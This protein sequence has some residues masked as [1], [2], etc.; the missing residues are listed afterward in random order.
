MYKKNLIR[1]TLILAAAGIIAKFLGFFFRIP[2]INMI[3]EEGIGLY[4][5]TYPLYTFLLALA[6]G[7]PV[8]LSKMISERIALNKKKEAV[9]IFRTSIIVMAIFGIS[10]SASLVV[11]SG[12]IINT[13]K[14]SKEAVY[15]LMGISLAP[16][17]TCLLSVFRGYFQGLQIMEPPAASQ[18]MEQLIRICAGVGLAYLLLPKGIDMA[19]GGAA[20]GAAAG[21]L[22]ALVWM[23][24][25]YRGNRIEC[26]QGEKTRGA[27]YLFGEM[28]RMAIPI[29]IGQAIGSIMA[30][31]DSVQVPGLLM[32]SGYSYQM[33]TRLYGQLTGKAHV[34]INVPLTLSMALAQST[35]PAIS[36]MNAIRSL[37]SIHK[38]IHTI[39]KFGM[40]IAL[41]CCAG[42]YALSKP[43]LMLI[44]QGMGD[45]WRLLQILSVA[46]LFIIIAQVCTSILN[47]IGKTLLPVAT[48]VF[49][50]IIK[51]VI[52]MA[53]IPVQ[54]LNIKAAAYSTLFSYAVVALLDF[55]FVVKYT[56]VRLPFYK[57]FVGPVISSAVM[58]LSAIFVYVKIQNWSGRG[59]LATL[60]SILVGAA[61]Y[62]VLILLTK[63]L[64]K[65]EFTGIIKRGL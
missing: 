27:L 47:G 33:A 58:I 45:G 65:D 55:I 24:V 21:A 64:T 31:I 56:R 44:F 59:N 35:V 49:G 39:F 28:L 29:S 60:L 22:A 6:A 54:S 40:I 11:F 50:C 37:K 10:S 16:V 5:L 18:I 36:E 41:P 14:W 34:L 4:Q 46:A 51:I 7:I 62:V 26:Y 43:I 57:T 12:T 38:T 19:A 53:F 23:M 15:S 63:T 30:L 9:K 8:A 3:G 2:L 48:M 25:K 42:L 1:G 32:S 17:F 13:F 20:F 61:M 52:S